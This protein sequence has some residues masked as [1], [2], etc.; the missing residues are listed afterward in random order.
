MGFMDKSQPNSHASNVEMRQS[1]SSMH[2]NMGTW[3]QVLWTDEPTFEIFGWRP[4]EGSLFAEEPL[5]STVMS[6]RGPSEAWWRLPVSLGLHFFTQCW[7]V[8]QGYWCPTGSSLPIMHYHYAAAGQRPDSVIKSFV[9]C[10]EDALE[11][12]LLAPTEP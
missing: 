6:V 12:M 7:R 3:Q 10:K 4:S 1:D 11:V 2:E 5:Y 8:C 9:Q